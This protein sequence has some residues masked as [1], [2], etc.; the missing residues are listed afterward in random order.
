MTQ[1]S[2]N[3]LK[4]FYPKIIEVIKEN[5][6][7]KFTF[8]LAGI[9]LFALS[10]SSVFALSKNT[11]A[12]VNGKKITQ[13][14]YQAHLKLRQAQKPKGQQQ[15]PVS[16][17][18]IL[19]ELINREVLLQKAKKLKLHKDKKVITQLKQLKDNVLIQAVLSQSPASKPVSDKELKKIY[20]QQVGNADPTEY[21]A[22]HI[23]V[24][25]EAAAK[26]LISELN[27]GEN[28]EDLAKKASTG[29]SVKYGG[30]LGWF[31]SEK[32]VPAFSKA[33]AKLKKG[34]HSQKPVKTQFGFHIIK[35]ED[36]RKR[37]LPKFEDVK[38]QILPMVQ[39]QRLQEYVMK[40]RNKAK[41]VVK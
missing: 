1:L 23:L 10:S 34:T 17:Q 31:S 27:D 38:N 26:K 35:L 16:R 37:T 7:K 14:Q 15:A 2:L 24:K 28:F 18:A 19:D 11:V 33:T 6:M 40:L 13:K 4:K 41:V 36:T 30:D 22:R 12:T 32:M 5:I 20:D 21:K 25:D 29:P 3:L 39:S 9:L 8:T